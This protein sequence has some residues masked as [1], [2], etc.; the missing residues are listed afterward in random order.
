MKF[1]PLLGLFLAIVFMVLSCKKQVVNTNNQLNEAD[2][3][4]I[5]QARIENFFETETAKMVIQKT[6]DSVVLSFAQQLLSEHLN[7]QSDLQIMGKIVGFTAADTID[8]AHAATLS[9]LDTLAGR[10]FDSTYIH[11]RLTDYQAAISFYT[12]EVKNGNQLNVR[13]YANAN[14]QN[15]QFDY[16]RA[17]SI[18][19]A[20]Y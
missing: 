15:I 4:F 16:S 5:K 13:S 20:F 7:S 3:I 1:K 12:D 9:Q 8:A 17:D 14:L 6:M 10:T 19:T 18:S 11:T 2:N